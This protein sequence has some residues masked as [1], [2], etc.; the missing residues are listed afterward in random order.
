MKGAFISA[1]TL[2][3]LQLACQSDIEPRDIA[4]AEGEEIARQQLKGGYVIAGNQAIDLGRAIYVFLVQSEDNAMR[5]VID[6]KTGRLIDVRDKT[7]DFLNAKSR[8]EA[9]DAKQIPS[10][11][12]AAEQAALQF[13]PGYIRKWFAKQEN[14]RLVFKIKIRNGIDKETRV[15]ID[16][17]TFAVLETAEDDTLD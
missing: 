8:G 9:I 3:V 17:D 14:G 10:R 7:E 4:I 15:T 11:R 2:T 5:V 6:A 13:A 12:Q 16:G 1:L